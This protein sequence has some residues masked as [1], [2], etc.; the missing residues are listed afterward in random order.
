MINFI[1]DQVYPLS[2]L[3]MIKFINDQVYQ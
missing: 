3:S 2:S 1:N